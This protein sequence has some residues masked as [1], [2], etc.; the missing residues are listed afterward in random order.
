MTLAIPCADYLAGRCRSCDRLPQPYAAQLL[1]KDHEARALLDPQAQAE[2]CAP[3]A[4]RV[5]GFRNKAKFAV[6]GSSTT[7]R[8][9]L[10]D[11][12]DLADCPLYPAVIRH[13]LAAFRELIA[14]ARI[15]PYDIAARRGELKYLLLSCDSAEAQLMAR[16]VL[17][18]TESLPRL[19]KAL[20][21]LQAAVPALRVVSANLQPEPKAILEG[22]QE[23]VLGEADHLPLSVNGVALRLTPQAFFQTHPDVAAMLYANAR[24][25]VG[26]L[27]APVA[28]AAD[29]YCG[30]GGFALHLAPHVDTMLGIER[31]MA[32]I[33]AARAAAADMGHTRVRFV[34][35]DVD[36]ELGRLGA[37]DLLIVNPPRRGLDPGLRGWIRAQRPRW[38]L[39]SSCNPATLARDLAELSG[40]RLRRAQVHDMFPHTAHYEVL[41]LAE[42]G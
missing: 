23:I 39:Y 22:P 38:L 8:F 35:G 34:A 1:A 32:A 15:P 29:L 10:P 41:T 11:G 21:T 17:R 40:Y 26:E 9:G 33:T 42:V 36:A 7:V 5:A 25:W 19:R 31:S 30:I 20:P 16:F 4:G 37:L 24:D 14:Q 12:T 27:A 18:S 3:V 28:Q 13:S 2:W 6:T